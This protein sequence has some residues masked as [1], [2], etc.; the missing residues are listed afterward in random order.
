[1]QRATKLFTILFLLMATQPLVA[2]EDGSVIER[3]VQDEMDRSMNELKGEDFD[4]PFFIRYRIIDNQSNHIIASMGS[5]QQVSEQ[6][7]RTKEIRVMAGDYEFNDESLDDN[8]QGGQAPG[9]GYN[10]FVVPLGEDYYGIRRSLWVTTDAIYKQAA[11]IHKAH[12]RKLEEDEKELDEVDHRYF[13]R[14][15]KIEYL[16]EVKEAPYSSKE[17]EEFAKTIS[18]IFL[19]YKDLFTS[20]VVINS[21]VSTAYFL[22]SEGVKY[23]TSTQSTNMV[24]TV[25]MLDDDAGMLFDTKPI[26]IENDG[27]PKALEVEV[28]IS[29]MVAKLKEQQEV[30]QFKDGYFGPIL[31]E[32]AAVA[33]L[34]DNYLMSSLQASTVLENENSFYSYGTVDGLDS[35]VGKQV[36][37]KNI[38][39]NLHT[40]VDLWNEQKLAGSYKIDSE[41]VMAPDTL[42]LIEDGILKDLMS[43]RTIK[44][45]GQKAN[46]TGSGPGVVSISASETES[47][48]ALKQQLIALAKETVQEY[49]IIIRDAAVYG[50][51]NN[52]NIY[53]VD[54]ESGEETLLKGAT[55]SEV[56]INHFKRIAAVSDKQ[57]VNDVINTTYITPAAILMQDMS[58]R[59]GFNQIKMQVPL[60]ESPLS[61]GDK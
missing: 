45:E 57:V 30:E 51:F 49:A 50:A 20:T 28:T 7:F 40:A 43:T 27:L 23:R 12:L 56:N 38:S 26:T 60:V 42:A 22:N 36:I 58:L 15:P 41:G 59:G 11:H 29:E 55:L 16:E 3:A 21:G 37:S 35:K 13:A 31:F 1:M 52:V 17:L 19:E 48:A 33:N 39:V 5:V 44:R 4:L 2:Q 14:I 32:G 25:T 53:K 9:V 8:G 24:L 54:L 47:K 46:G 6:P 10:D 18:A 61:Q 34:F